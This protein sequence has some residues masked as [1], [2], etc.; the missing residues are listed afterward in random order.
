MT[1]TMPSQYIDLHSWDILY[2]ENYSS[3]LNK[4]LEIINL[5]AH[6]KVNQ[7]GSMN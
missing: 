2:M 1:D 7:E 6:Q 3:D 5:V 4:K